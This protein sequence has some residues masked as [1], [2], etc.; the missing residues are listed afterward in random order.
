MPSLRLRFP[1]LHD[2]LDRVGRAAGAVSVTAIYRPL[3][4]FFPEASVELLKLALPDASSAA[5]PSVVL[6]CLKL[7]LPVGT[8]P[9]GDVTLT[10]KVTA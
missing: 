7:T 5:V 3:T 2:L 6:P 10:L 1:S 9:R 4:L 8:M